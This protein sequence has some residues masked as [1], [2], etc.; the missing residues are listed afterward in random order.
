MPGKFRRFFG[1]VFLFFWGAGVPCCF[2]VV[3]VWRDVLGRCLFWDVFTLVLVFL[4]SLFRWRSFMVFM[5]SL[6]LFF[7]CLV[8][9]VFF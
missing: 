1:L 8:W 9:R 4:V 2:F 3:F 6:F 7:F 5:F